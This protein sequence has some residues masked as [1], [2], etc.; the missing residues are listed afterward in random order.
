MHEPVSPNA[1]QTGPLVEVKGLKIHFPLRKGVLFTRTIGQVKAVDDISFEIRRGETFGLVG[2]SGCG[3]TTVAR[4]LLQ[5][6]SP[7]AGHIHFDG[8]GHG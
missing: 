6:V 3:K 2:E 5:L 7:T 4:A 8:K 1:E